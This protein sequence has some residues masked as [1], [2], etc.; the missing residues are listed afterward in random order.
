MYCDLFMIVPFAI[1]MAMM[2]SIP[3]LAKYRPCAD[4][5]S[6]PVISSVLIFILFSC[7]T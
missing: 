6:F 5:I 3:T 2:P 7:G 1:T 4:L